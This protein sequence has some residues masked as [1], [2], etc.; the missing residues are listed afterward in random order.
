MSGGVLRA[1]L[2]LLFAMGNHLA[3]VLEA[4]HGFA[5]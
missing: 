1:N 4:L 2:G 5:G 3:G